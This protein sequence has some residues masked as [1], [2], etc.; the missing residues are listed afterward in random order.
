[1][2]AGAVLCTAIVSAPTALFAVEA[3][4]TQL[5]ITGTRIWVALEVRDLLRDN[6]LEL[7]RDGRAVFLQ[8]ETDLWEDRRVLDRVVVAAPPATWRIDQEQ[9][10]NGINLQDQYG[11]SIRQA[12]L[13]QPLSLRLDLGPAT[14]VEDESTYYVHATLTA[15][16]VDER[17]IEQ[18]GNTLFGDEQ[19]TRGLAGLGRFVFRTLLRMGKYFESATAETT[20]RRLSGKD[21]RSGAF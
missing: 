21:I 12:D 15:A 8:L 6:F 2:I 20:S 4:V 3:R 10:G 11:E 13:R 18:A 17:D 16:T 7:L 5:R 9:N 1:M 19:T 14:R